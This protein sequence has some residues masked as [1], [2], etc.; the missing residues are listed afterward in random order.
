MDVSN[1]SCIAFKEKLKVIDV[2]SEK[3][4]YTQLAKVNVKNKSIRHLTFIR[5]N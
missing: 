3:A 2:I 4:S 5:V 1:K